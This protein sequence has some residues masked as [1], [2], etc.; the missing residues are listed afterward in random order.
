MLDY[1]KVKDVAKELKSMTNG[2]GL[3]VALECAAGE[4]AKGMFSEVFQKS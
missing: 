3:D 4:Y 2:D 1:S